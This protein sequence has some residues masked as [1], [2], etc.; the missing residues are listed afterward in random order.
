ML[1][2]IPFWDPLGDIKLVAIEMEGLLLST[3]GI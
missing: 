1:N 2:Y 3:V